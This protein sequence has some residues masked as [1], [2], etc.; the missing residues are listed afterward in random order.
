MRHLCRYSH[1]NYMV[2]S[3]ILSSPTNQGDKTMRKKLPLVV[4][5]LCLLLFACEQ[6]SQV[7]S[8]NLSKAAQN[9]EIARR[10]VFINAI[11]DKYLFEIMGRCAIEADRRDNQLE[12]TCKTPEG[13]KKHFLGLS[14]NVSYLV[15]QLNAEAVSVNHYRVTFKPQSI[16]PAIDIRGDLT[17]PLP[18]VN[19]GK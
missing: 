18:T 4:M 15:E 6:D 9:F 19:K 11:T 3:S 1:M 14:D 12:V 13:F 16:I 5:P 2:E 8:R 7:A 17:L 10:V